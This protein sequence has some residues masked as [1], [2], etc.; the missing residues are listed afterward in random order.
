MR[1][2]SSGCRT[3]APLSLVRESM[4]DEPFMPPNGTC[5]SAPA[6]SLIDVDD[7]GLDPGA[8]FQRLTAD[9]RVKIEAESPG[10]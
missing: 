7:S 8:R 10:T 9:T 3:R 1:P 4:R 2:F 6:V 5:G